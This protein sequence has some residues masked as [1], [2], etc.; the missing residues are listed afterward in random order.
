ML[1]VLLVKLALLV[2]LVKLAL[3]VKL[4]KL[5]KLEHT[6]AEGPVG[7]T[8][9]K[10]AIVPTKDRNRYVGLMCT[11]MPEARFE[12]V[13]RI[14]TNNNSKIKHSIDETFIQVCEKDSISVV[15][16]VPSHPAMVGARIEDSNIIIEI[17]RYSIPPEYVTVKLNGIRDGF[18]G[19][20]FE[21]FTKDQ[22]ESNYR[23]W[24]NW[25]K[26]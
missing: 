23:F 14:K 10:Y 11:E 15:S 26:S 6:G 20:R 8:G 12:D 24:G 5:A 17:D 22:A 7:A 2:K 16:C 19:I 25:S 9:S 18:G 1:L 21:N 4:V 3:L 13:I